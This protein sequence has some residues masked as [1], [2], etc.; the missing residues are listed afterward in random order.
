MANGRLI[1]VGTSNQLI[2]QVDAKNFEDAF[3]KIAMGG[4][5]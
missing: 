5:V 4:E 2:E 1:V 3:V